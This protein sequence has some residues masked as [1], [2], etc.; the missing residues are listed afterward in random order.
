MTLRHVFVPLVHAAGH[1]KSLAPV[2]EKLARAFAGETSVVI[3]NVDADSE[4]SLGES[5]GVSGYPTIKLFPA[6]T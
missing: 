2:Y 5:Y 6:G 1:C 4:K 3:A